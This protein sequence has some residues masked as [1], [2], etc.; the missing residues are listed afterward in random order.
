MLKAKPA[1][2]PFCG[3]P[4]APPQNLGFQFSDF[5]AGFCDCGAIY[6]SDVTGH[7]RGAAFV[8]ALLLACGGNWDLAW[9]LDP[10]EDYQEYVVEHYDQKSH[11]VFGDPS[12]RV[13]VRGVLI[14]LRLSDELRELSAEKIAKLKA[15]RRLKEIPPPGFK[16]KRLRRQEIENLLREN[17]EKEIVFHCRFM[18]VNLSI[19]RKVLYSADPLL[20]WKAV[21]TLGEAAQA[22]L[23]TRPDITADLIKRLIYSSADSAASAWG[24][25]ETVGE[26]IRR[27]PDRFGL[28]VKNLLAFL[29]YPE[30]RPGALWALYRIAQGKPTLIKNERYWMILELLEDKDPLVKALAT[31]VCQHAGL[32]DALPKLEELLG[33]QST[34]EIFDPEEK[35]FKNV[36]VATLAR[37]AIKTLERI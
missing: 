14:F 25:L 5:D 18:P 6:V 30:F 11:Q 8:E 10:E 29:K 16:P 20:R 19:L 36:T 2:C 31:L 7:N 21:L 32:I 35:I 33:D 15:E 34:I 9:E 4:V 3:R 17:K 1:L 26:I 12:E 22:V 37:E 24:A 23:K 27:E 13:N 28:F